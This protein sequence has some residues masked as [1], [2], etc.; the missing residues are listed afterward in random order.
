MGIPFTEQTLDDF[1]TRPRSCAL[2]ATRGL[3]GD[4]LVLGA[5]GKMGLHLCLMLKRCFQQNGQNNR[6]IAVSRF[7]TPDSRN[8][9]EENDIGTIVCDLSNETELET[10]PDAANIWFTAGVKF[11]TSNQPELLHKMNIEMP[12]LVAKRF[13]KSRIV[14]L[15]TGCVYAFVPIDSSGSTEL[16]ATESISEYAESCRGREAAFR[17]ASEE[18]G[19]LAVLIRLNYSVEMRYGVLVDIAQKVLSNQPIDISMS[20]FNCIWQGDALS[21][22]IASIKLAGSPAEILNVSGPET[23]SIRETAEAFGKLFDQKPVFVGEE[24]ETTWLN[25]ASKAIGL[26]G[27]PEVSADQ[28]IIWIAKWLKSG[29]ETLGKPTKFE[30][31]SGKF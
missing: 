24:Q 7:S 26:F 1:I 2:H 11:G 15:S 23:L 16:D 13:N 20:R 27:A 31:R 21:H 10:L 22:I 30:V 6:V 29:G 12:T 18:S 17:C 5:A 14:A 3:K 25:N 28:M 4:V 19:L 9:F 8:Q